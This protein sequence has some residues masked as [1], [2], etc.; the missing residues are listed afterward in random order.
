MMQS[1]KLMTLSAVAVAYLLMGDMN[2][3]EQNAMANWLMLV[4]QTLETNA[5]FTALNSSNQVDDKELLRK[6]KNALEQEINRD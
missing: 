4:A 6:L 2:S 5:F 1:S 3:N